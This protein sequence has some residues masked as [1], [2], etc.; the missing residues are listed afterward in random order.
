LLLPRPD[1]E[2]SRISSLDTV[3]L[4]DLD[5]LFSQ[6]L[7]E[8][9]DPTALPFARFVGQMNVVAAISMTQSPSPLAP[10]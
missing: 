1:D 3:D 9:Y 8:R 4:L 7:I 10:P 2:L 6:F 5:Q